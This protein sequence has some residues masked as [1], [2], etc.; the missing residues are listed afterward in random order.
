MRSLLLAFA[1]L[2]AFPDAA[3]AGKCYCGNGRV[4]RTS[5]DCTSACEG[6]GGA[7]HWN[8]KDWEKRRERRRQRHQEWVEQREDDA[9]LRRAL[10]AREAATNAVPSR[11]PPTRSQATSSNVTNVDKTRSLDGVEGVA[12][13]EGKVMIPKLPTREQIAFCKNKK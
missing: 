10:R 8:S 11:R 5:R 2:W 9:H 4:V 12:C 7:R 3:D 1:L 6:A 13:F